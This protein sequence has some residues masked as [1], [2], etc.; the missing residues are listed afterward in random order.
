MSQQ[1]RGKRMLLGSGLLA[2]AAVCLC[3]VVFIWPGLF[4]LAPGGFGAGEG[5]GGGS[6]KPIAEKPQ[7]DKP[8]AKK[9]EPAKPKVETIKNGFTV[10][11][12]GTGQFTTIGEALEKVDRPG[13]TIRILDD[14]VYTETLSI[15]S[16]RLHEGLTLESRRGATLAFPRDAK[17]GL[18]ILNVPRVTVRG[19]V[20][21]ANGQAY[22]VGV[23][24][25]SPGVVLQDLRCYGKNAATTTGM[26]LDSL[27]LSAEDEPV[28]VRNCTIVGCGNGFEV[29]GLNPA[30]KAITSCRRLLLRDNRV[31]D[32]N[33]GIWAVGRINE[34][35]IVANRFVDCS[36]ASI[37]LN[38]LAEGS[39]GILAANNSIKAQSHCL[40]V[41]GSMRGAEGVEIRNNVLIAEAGPDMVRDGGAPGIPAGWRIDH[42]WRQVRAPAADSPEAKTW[43][44]NVQDKVVDKLPLLTLDPKHADF[45][46]I[47]DTASAKAG[48]GG[49][50]PTYVGAVPP[51]GAEPWD[52]QKTWD[53]RMR[54]SPEKKGKTGKE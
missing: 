6:D 11:K 49:D 19:L 20:V 53:A 21:R 36:E 18:L 52:W 35:L 2:A 5:P 24:A 51:A 26:I 43:L 39:G 50:L 16:R 27:G 25:Y 23:G 38:D 44:A 40:H 31:E 37:R 30:T 54:K 32:C 34:A 14:A 12:D 46:R 7:P 42:N 47:K 8:I 28:V 41:S 22:C 17:V 4:G 13:M 3:L 1:K 15:R 48:A 29:L 10:A 33:V 45:F 9:P